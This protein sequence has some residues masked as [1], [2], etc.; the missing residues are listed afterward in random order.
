MPLSAFWSGIAPRASEVYG[1]TSLRGLAA[2][3]V[4]AYHAALVAQADEL[5]WGPVTGFLLSSYLFVDLFFVLSGF[6]MVEAYGDRLQAAW[7]PGGGGLREVMS[8]WR[9]RA[10]KI[11]P[12]YYIWLGIAIGFWVLRAA[13]FGNPLLHQDCFSQAIWRHVLLAQTFTEVCVSF[14]TP[15]WS[16]VVELVAYLAFPLLLLALPVWPVLAVAGVLLYASVLSVWGTIDV[17]TDIQSVLRCLAGFMLG[18]VMARLALLLPGAAL[19]WGQVPALV[20]LVVCVALEA[21]AAA[22]A[23]IPVVV[24]LTARNQGPLVALLRK[25][26]FY[27]LGRASFSIYLAHVPLLGMLNVILSKL[28]VELGLPLASDWRL[29]VPISV[30]ICGAVGVLAYHWV[31]R[32]L[33]AMPALR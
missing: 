32:R 4:V 22:L 13:Y 14:N 5:P 24:V 8:Y 28:G 25:R 20:G 19:R 6:I 7:R 30:V 3:S 17:L 27:V 23:C 9:R 11:L 2:L 16:I 10:L 1:H 26:L 31:E 33:E 15:L 18:M 29:F 21:Q 12:N